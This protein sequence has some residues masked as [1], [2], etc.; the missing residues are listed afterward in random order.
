MN[1]DLEYMSIVREYFDLSDFYTRD[2]VVLCTESDKQ[3]VIESLANKLYVHIRDHVDQIDFGTIPLSKGDITRI[4]NYENLIDCLNVIKQLIS[5]Y[6]EK[7]ELVDIVYTAVNNI[8]KR[9]RIFEKAFNLHIE[10]PMMIYNTMT[11]SCVTSVSLLI[12]TCVEY[13][14][15]GKG[16]IK[17]SFNKT[18][19]YKSMNHVLFKSLRQFNNECNGNQL[20]KFMEGCIT[21]NM[22]RL[23]EAY[24]ADQTSLLY[25]QESNIGLVLTALKYVISFRWVFSTIFN[26]IRRAV[27][28]YYYKR[29]SIADYWTMQADFLQMN[30]ENL[31]YRDG[32][33]DENKRKEVYDKQMK[34]VEKFRK[35]ANKFMID[36]KKAQK[37]S[38][39]QANREDR[40][41]N[42]YPDND[43]KDGDMF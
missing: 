17:T 29:Q 26:M 10:F 5:E 24:N 6:G 18:A 33:E 35:I 32:F 37:Q 39:D 7:P 25:L 41:R 14:K 3:S 40:D 42:K 4:E 43:D 23:K 19:Y 1:N 20:D 31:Q 38:D 2:K 16:N 28:Y 36:D 9:K 12:A 11:L 30:A 13:I 27:Y 21:T 15:D 8:Q 34:Y 22:T